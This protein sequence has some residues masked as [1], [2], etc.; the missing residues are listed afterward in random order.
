M[1]NDVAVTRPLTEAQSGEW[2][3]GIRAG[4][5]APL[6]GDTTGVTASEIIHMQVGTSKSPET[7]TATGVSFNGD[8][9]KRLPACLRTSF[10]RERMVAQH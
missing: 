7:S 6:V 4:R 5:R 9:R 2:R 8:V 3:A 10:R 1:S